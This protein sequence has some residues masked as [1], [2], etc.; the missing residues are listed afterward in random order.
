[1]E[2]KLWDILF[3]A[4]LTQRKDYIIYD[5]SIV[6]TLCLSSSLSV[7][8]SHHTL[9]KEMSQMIQKLEEIFF[10]FWQVQCNS[11]N[12]YLSIFRPYPKS[13]MATIDVSSYYC[14]RSY[15]PFWPS[16]FHQNSSF[17]LNGNSSKHT[18][19]NIRLLGFAH[20]YS[21]LIRLFLKELLAVLT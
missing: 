6:V 7:N 13:K 17:I 14:W 11:I 1:M 21:S 16:L 8:L 10:F 4:H 3:F 5:V 12:S 2:K 20:L 9:K 15:C 18:F 19:L